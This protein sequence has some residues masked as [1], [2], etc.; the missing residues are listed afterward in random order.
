MANHDRVSRRSFLAFLAATPLLANLPGKKNIPVGLELY[1]VREGLKTDLMGTVRGVGRMGYQCVEF[2]APY[3]EWTVDYAR[4]VRK[5]LDELGVR[6]Y[7]THNERK[8]FTP[9]GL[10]KAIELNQALGAHY[11]VMSH[12][13]EVKDV[14]GWKQVAEVLNKANQQ[15]A[16]HGMHAG[17]H[18]HDLEW[19]PVDGQRPLELIASNTEK[20]I[21]LQLDV[22]TCLATGNDPVA[23]VEAHP[24]RIRSMHLKEWS[25]DKGYHVLFGEGVAPWKKLLAAAESKGGVEYYLIEQEGSDYSELETAERCLAAYKK[26]RAEK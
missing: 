24:G 16:G 2:Y 21:A 23:W 6:C 11:I 22:G 12:P 3:F 15:L 10:N 20:N 14:D 9:E 25:P 1:S 19:K 18:N 7:S 4:Q 8:S 17:Y 26:L 5:E 13:G